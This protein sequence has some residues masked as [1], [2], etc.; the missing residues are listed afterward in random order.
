MERLKNK[1]EEIKEKIEKIISE[2]VF[3]KISPFK[4]GRFYINKMRERVDNVIFLLASLTEE[5]EIG[6]KEYMLSKKLYGELYK[7]ENDSHLSSAI[8]Y[9]KKVYEVFQKVWLLT[10]CI[11]TKDK[12]LCEYDDAPAGI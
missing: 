8:E 10:E 6:S 9:K 2:H 12:Y 1:I 7:L 4:D 3:E 5:T 11:S